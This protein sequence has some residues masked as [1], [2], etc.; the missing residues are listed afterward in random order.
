M[1]AHAIAVRPRDGAVLPRRG[2]VRIDPGSH[3]AV[4]L[5]VIAGEPEVTAGE[6][7]VIAS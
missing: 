1:N 7:A 3:S 4:W 5:E 6:S 2:A